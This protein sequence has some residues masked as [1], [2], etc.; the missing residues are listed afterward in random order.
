M[1]TQKGGLD[2]RGAKNGRFKSEGGGVIYIQIGLK[3]VSV[4]YK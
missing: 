4:S 3:Y 2:L 1:D